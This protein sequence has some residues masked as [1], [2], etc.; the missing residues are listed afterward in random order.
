MPFIEIITDLKSQAQLSKIINKESVNN[1]EIMYIREKNIENIKNIR[2]DTLVLN[3]AI[4][5]IEIIQKIV[6]NTKNLVLNIDLNEN[7]FEDVNLISFGYN[8]KSDITIS[9]IEEDEVLIC[10]QNT[11]T[12][13]YGRKIE[14]QEIKVN[15]KSDINVY[16]IMIIIALTALY[17]R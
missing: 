15:V 7:N 6:N 3:Q 11:I 1:C 14:P 4:D 8:S 16:N 17:A 9:S 10:I 13:I 12:S 2:L 5:K